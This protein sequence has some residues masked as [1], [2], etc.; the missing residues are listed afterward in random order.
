MLLPEGANEYESSIEWEC[1]GEISDE[2]F[3]FGDVANRKNIIRFGVRILLFN[4]YGELCIVKSEK[5]GY[6]QLPGGGIEKDENIEN[7]LRREAREEAGYEIREIEP[8]GYIYERRGSTQNVHPWNEIISFV[9]IAKTEREVGT[10][11]TDEEISEGFKPIFVNLEEAVKDF[12]NQARK[13]NDYSGRFASWRD[14]T[15]VEK[16]GKRMS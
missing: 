4:A 5:Y 10:S 7:A 16:Y 9:F 1:L 6:I 2:D 14:S 13:T 15:I 8:L 11:Y 3:G 12:H